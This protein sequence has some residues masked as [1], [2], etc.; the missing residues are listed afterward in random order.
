[1][2][3]D[4]YD[5]D[6]FVLPEPPVTDT[7]AEPTKVEQVSPITLEV[8]E[9]TEADEP[10]VTPV[11]EPEKDNDVVRYEYWQSEATKAKNRLA[12]LEKKLE[13]PQ[14]EDAP[15]VAPE[16][17]SD[18][19]EVL[20]YNTALSNYTLKQIQK[21]QE[22]TQQTEKQREEAEKQQAI[23]QY[24]TAKLTEVTKSPQKSQNI[25]NFFANSP[26]LQ[27]P[28][29]YNVMYDAAQ[30][31]LGNKTS[32]TQVK[33]APPPPMG[34]DSGIQTK[35]VDDAFNDIN[36]TKKII[37]IIKKNYKWQQQ[38]N[39]CIKGLQ[40]FGIIYRQT[41]FLRTATGCQNTLRTK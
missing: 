39:I 33:K 41:R 36:Y 1:M 15:P 13:P 40:F 22:R 23:K 5:A 28:E 32:P 34:G 21:M 16:D 19:I 37:Q 17:T 3:E 4:N 27:N 8:V 24:T 7:P 9:P 35:S 14:Q 11:K 26:H 25:V 38:K 29:V 2:K 31:F 10:E 18:P 20:K 30:A 6:T 12:E